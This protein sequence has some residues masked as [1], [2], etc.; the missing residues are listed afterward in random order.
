MWFRRV[1]GKDCEYESVLSEK[2]ALS[3]PE[4]LLD[5]LNVGSRNCHRTLV[6]SG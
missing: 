5:S 1:M 2:G 6:E 3:I 4:K